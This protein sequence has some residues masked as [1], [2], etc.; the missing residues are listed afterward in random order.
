MTPLTNGRFLDKVRLEGVRIN[1]LIFF[2]G[3]P[4][5]KVLKGQEFSAM[6]ILSKGQKTKERLG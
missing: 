2:I 3:A 6:G 4:Q 5:Q 1:H